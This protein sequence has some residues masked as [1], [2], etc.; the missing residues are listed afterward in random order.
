[1]QNPCLPTGFVVSDCPPPHLFAEQYK[2]YEAEDWNARTSKYTAEVQGRV[3]GC[4]SMMKGYK[5][6]HAKA[7]AVL[8]IPIKALTHTGEPLAPKSSVMEWARYAKDD[9]FE[10]LDLGP[11]KEN[12]A[13][14]A[15]QG[16]GLNPEPKLLDT[17]TAM[18]QKYDRWQEDAALP[19]LGDVD[20]PLPDQVDTVVV[21]AG[22]SG[23]YQAAE[24][25]KAGKTVVVFDRYHCIGGVWQFYGN[26]YSRV[27]TS[28]IG[29]RIVDKTGPWKRPN[30]DHTPRRDILKDIYSI[31]ATHCKDMVRCNINVGKVDKMP[32]GSFEIHVKHLKTGAEK[33]LKAGA[34]TFHVNRRIGK[35]REVDWENSKAFKGSILYGYGNEVRGHDFWGKEVLVVGAGAFAFE[36]VRTS[37]EHGASHVTLLG[38]RDGTTCP[39]WIDMIAF[40]RPLDEHLV[41]NKSGNMISFECWQKCYLDAGLRKPKCWEDGLLKPNNHTI[42]V[43]DLGFIAGYHGMFKLQVGEIAKVV[44]DGTA[45]E[46]KDGSLINCQIIL[47][48]TGF[49]LNDEVSQITGYEKMQPYGLLDFNLNYSA[50][51]LLDGGQFGSGKDRTGIEVDQGFTWEDYGKGLAVFKAMGFNEKHIA[52]MGNPFGSGQGGPIDFQSKYFAWLV[53][54][55]ANQKALLTQG[56]KAEQ[57]VTVLWAS[58]I[59]EFSHLTLMRL[60]ASLSRLA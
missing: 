51:P 19:D 41:T 1:M 22:I 2:P 16:Y 30:E 42:S 50:E 35:K 59:G 36:N 52:P 28:E 55:A 20:G 23:V 31:A 12:K 39:K 21:G 7:Q 14:L 33:V 48:C 11:A 56:G 49:H 5:Y 45:V 38:R 54:N 18:V 4:V 6:M 9:D 37:L 10:M 13:Y 57:D 40:L 58:Q 29:Y 8:H 46:L 3:S 60:I 44:P 43:S 47:K 17:I 24:L 25:V 27:N 34:V 32:D 26:D 53:A 15:G